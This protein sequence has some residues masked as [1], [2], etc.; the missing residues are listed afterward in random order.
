MANERRCPFFAANPNGFLR[1]PNGN[2][3]EKQPPDKSHRCQAFRPV[4]S[5]IVAMAAGGTVGWITVFPDYGMTDETECAPEDGRG[6]LS[7]HASG[8][9][10]QD[11][12]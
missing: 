9:T 2:I 11:I 8:A 4:W 10:G 3:V 12:G 7:R 5:G 1:L 6:G